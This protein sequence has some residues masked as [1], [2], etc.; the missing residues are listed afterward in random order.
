MRRCLYLVISCLLCFLF[1]QA[2]EETGPGGPWL[3][4]PLLT[5]SG[6]VM[7]KGQIEIAPYV[8]SVTNTGEYNKD[9]KSISIPHFHNIVFPVFLYYGITKTVDVLLIPQVVYNKTQGQSFTYLGDFSSFLDYQLIF[10]DKYKWFPGIKV[11]V[12]ETFPLGKY[13]KLNPHKKENG[14]YW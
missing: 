8:Y 11:S 6:T 4:G 1:L 5:F 10:P 3:T 2:A 7:D 9:W 12:G 14:F 13:Q